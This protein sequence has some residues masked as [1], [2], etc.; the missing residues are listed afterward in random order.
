[1]YTADVFGSSMSVIAS[2]QPGALPLKDNIDLVASLVAN[3]HTGDTTG[4]I[5]ADQWQTSNARPAI[6]PTCN[7]EIIISQNFLVKDSSGGQICLACHDP[8][9]VR[10]AGRSTPCLIGLPARMPCRPAKS[11][12]RPCSVATQRSRQTACI[13]CHAPHNAAGAARLLRG[14]NEQDCI[15]CHNGGSNISPMAALCGCICR[16]CRAHRWGIPFPPRANPMNES[17]LPKPRGRI[18]Q[19]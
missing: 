18:A 15:A 4:A 3:G 2:V 6:I 17:W 8:T 14:Q 19:Q 10:L 1:M 16:I 9:C 7:P 5:E 13:S 12:P 11:R